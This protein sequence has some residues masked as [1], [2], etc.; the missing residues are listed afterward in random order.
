MR[1]YQDKVNHAVLA[2]GYGVEDGL[3]YWTIKNSWSLPPCLLASLLPASR[4][5]ALSP[6]LS[7]FFPASLSP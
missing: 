7:P 1:W 4:P 6:S 5:L 2:V 3:D